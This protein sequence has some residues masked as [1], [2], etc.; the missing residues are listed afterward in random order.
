VSFADWHA[1]DLAEVA[2]ARPPAPR[3]KFTTL[4]EMLAVLDH[5]VK[6]ADDAGSGGQSRKEEVSE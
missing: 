1:I 4:A 3:K 2:A 5:R 6:A